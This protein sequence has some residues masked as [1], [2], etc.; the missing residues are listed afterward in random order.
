MDVNFLDTCYRK[1][2]HSDK[3]N[4]LASLLQVKITVRIVFE[5]GMNSF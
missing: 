2:K 5:L 4:H 3:R 1:I